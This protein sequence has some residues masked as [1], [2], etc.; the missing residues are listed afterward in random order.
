MFKNL[1]VRTKL[2]ILSLSML[3][4]FLFIAAYNLDQQK[5]AYELSLS[6]LEHSLNEDYDAQIKA[7]VESVISLVSSIYKKQQSGFYTEEQAKKTAADI[8]RDLRYG[9]SGYFWVDTYDGD[10]V[11][12]LGND[13]EGTNRWDAQDVNGSYFIRDIVT[14]GKQDGGGFTDYYFPKEGATESD[15]KRAYS[16]A[17][18]PYQWVIGTGNYID[19][20][21]VIALEK[22]QIQKDNYEKSRSIVIGV[23]IFSILVLG[24][25][26]ICI[27]TEIIQALKQSISFMNVL[28][29]GDYS[30]TLP[31][32]FL[33]RKDD[34]GQLA[35]AIENMKD[36]SNTL[37]S[38]VQSEADT[39]QGNVQMVNTNLISLNDEIS[40]ISATTEELAASMEETAATSQELNASS[41]EINRAVQDMAERSQE[42]AKQAAEISQRAASMKNHVIAS[43]EKT[44]STRAAI[45]KDLEAALEQSR[46]VS[47]IY[48]LSESIMAITSQTNLLAL[49]ASIEAA[50]AGE[51]GKGFAVV[52]NEIGSLAEQSKDSVI[53]I[54]QVTE[55]VTSAVE[56]LAS[57]ASRLLQFISTD[58]SA[59]YDTFMDVGLQYNTDAG[60]V[61]DLVSDFSAS[62]QELSTVIQNISLSIQEISRAASEGAEGTTDIAEKA[63]SMTQ[64]SETVL[65]ETNKTKEGTEHLMR[66]ISKFKI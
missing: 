50:R 17:F 9:E 56:N 58:I 51:A 36:A 12:L 37:I 44:S 57:N 4:G 43:R 21:E 41:D 19:E 8:I 45:Q 27:A 33:K 20:L 66:E 53:K 23:L 38:N 31:E 5:Q 60:F 29:S 25:I 18:E 63:S 40:S 7:E 13:T 24:F 30:V 34:F 46:I 64:Q 26:T 52:A 59:D 6:T 65:S 1:K 10:N 47:E 28:A 16:L 35:R 2:L 39:M 15:P 3:I 49:N 61:N 11:V 54:Q 32:K 42:G 55:E 62:S 22:T 14:A 48:K